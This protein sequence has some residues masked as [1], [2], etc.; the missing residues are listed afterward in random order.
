MCLALLDLWL[1]SRYFETIL[2][3]CYYNYVGCAANKLFVLRDIFRTINEL[4]NTIIIE[5]FE[6]FIGN[7]IGT[8]NSIISNSSRQ[9]KF[10]IDTTIN[11][12]YFI[13]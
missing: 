8:L 12:I 3:L 9:I 13:L 5:K 1:L 11:R 4:P 10:N 2:G 6:L 7:R